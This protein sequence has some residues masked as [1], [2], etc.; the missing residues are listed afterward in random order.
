MNE[1]ALDFLRAR[2]QA[3][4]KVFSGVYGE[5]VIVDLEKFCRANESTFHID[6]RI[7]GI[8]QG[9]REV[10]LRVSNHL[11]LTEEELTNLYNPGGE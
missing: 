10:W 11:N 7:E 4:H 2:A 3:Y 6:P 9:R 1:K 8:M 5:R